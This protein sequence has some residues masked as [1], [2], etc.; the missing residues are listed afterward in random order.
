MAYMT[1]SGRGG[2]YPGFQ[3]HVVLQPGMKQG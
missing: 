2:Q 1:G 3:L